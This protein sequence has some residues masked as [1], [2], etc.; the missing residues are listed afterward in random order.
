[1]R[2]VESAGNEEGLVRLFAQPLDAVVGGMPV[3]KIVVLQLRVV[4]VQVI[5]N[6]AEPEDAAVADA[7]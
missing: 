5:K 6:A 1:M 2:F 4:L 3:E 7:K